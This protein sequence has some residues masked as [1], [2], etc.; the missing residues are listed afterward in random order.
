MAFIIDRENLAWCAGFFD[1]EG[2]FSTSKATTRHPN[3]Y[4]RV[5]ISQVNREVLD[6]FRSTVG[7]GVVRGPY[8][9]PNQ[10]MFSYN[11]SNWPEIQHLICVLWPWLGEVKKEQ[12]LRVISNCNKTQLR[13]IGY[14]RKGHSIEEVGRTKWDQCKECCRKN[15]RN[16]RGAK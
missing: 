11:L 4:A 16:Y 14:C 2:C 13:L 8:D 3:R 15:A 9:R 10:P 7:V 6:K 5:N 12:A 1:G